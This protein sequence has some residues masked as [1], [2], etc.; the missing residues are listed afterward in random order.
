MKAHDIPLSHY[1]AVK[2]L[3]PR[4]R[5]ESPMAYIVRLSVLAGGIDPQDS[6]L[7]AP[8]FM[9][10]ASAATALPQPVDVPDGYRLPYRD[11]DADEIGG[12]R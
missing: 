4:G 9:E 1:A 10:W 3:N 2:Q 11:D 8:D 12:E 5:D 6:P 7:H